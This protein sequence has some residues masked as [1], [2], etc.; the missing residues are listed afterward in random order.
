MPQQASYQS[1]LGTILRW[2]GMEHMHPSVVEIPLPGLR[3]ADT[4]EVTTFDFISQFHSL[5][6]DRELN[7]PENLVVNQQNPFTRFIAPDGRL[8]ECLSGSWYNNAWEHMEATMDCNFMTPIILYIDKTKL[9]L[10]G[11]LTL[12]PVTM[13]LSI[14]TEAT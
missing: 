12:F 6:S 5:L 11:K 13:S 1:Q 8:G 7:I 3:A 9:S 10:T 14:F 2:V 4:I